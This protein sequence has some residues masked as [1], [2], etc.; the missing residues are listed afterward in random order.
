MAERIEVAAVSA[1]E[2]GEFGAGTDLQMPAEKN[3]GMSGLHGVH[4]HRGGEAGLIVGQH[5]TRDRQPARG[6]G[7]C[8][9]GLHKELAATRPEH[10]SFPADHGRDERFIVHVLHQWLADPEAVVVHAGVE[11]L[12]LAQ[13]TA[14]EGAEQ[15]VEN[16]FLCGQAVAGGLELL[17]ESAGAQSGEEVDEYAGSQSHRF[18][19]ARRIVGKIA[20]LQFMLE[21]KKQ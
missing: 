8:A 10:V 7:G 13:L 17:G 16:G 18:P 19:D 4:E 9:G 12:P 1:V 20:T 21:L 3:A 14:A 6:A 11:D 15:F 2:L 5:F